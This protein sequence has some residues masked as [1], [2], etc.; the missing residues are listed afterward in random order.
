MYCD[1][2][3]EGGSCDPSEHPNS[4][5]VCAM[6]ACIPDFRIFDW[7]GSGGS[8]KEIINE[9]FPGHPRASP[10]KKHSLEDNSISEGD[11]TSAGDGQG[12]V[13]KAYVDDFYY[14]YN[15]INFHEDLTYDPIEDINIKEDEDVDQEY[16]PVHTPSMGKGNTEIL[17]TGSSHYQLTTTGPLQAS[18]SPSSPQEDQNDI[19]MESAV[20]MRKYDHD[21]QPT[22]ISNIQEG[23][24]E[25]YVTPTTTHP[26][27]VTVLVSTSS[28]VFPT[29]PVQSSGPLPVTQ[30]AVPE[31]TASLPSTHSS[32][33]YSVTKN[34]QGS[35][36]SSS[37]SELETRYNDF[38][39][40]ALDIS[41]D[42]GRGLQP[43]PDQTTHQT[44]SSRT[45]IPQTEKNGLQ[46]NSSQ[47]ILPS[48]P[49]DSSD[50]LSRS[51]PSPPSTDSAE[52][53]SLVRTT[54]HTRPDGMTSSKP[55]V[56]P[57][58]SILP[59]LTT[60]TMHIPDSNNGESTYPHLSED[61]TKGLNTTYSNQST[62]SPM[63]DDLRRSHWRVGNWTEVSLRD[64]AMKGSPLGK[65]CLETKSLQIE[66]PNNLL[67]H[68]ACVDIPQR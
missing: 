13:G 3:L 14:D 8:S 20:T 24:N 28:E 42:L 58:P 10:G 18:L 52:T 39:N 50:V 33:Q 7:T 30:H 26:D 49:K 59:F 22:P 44:P 21:E 45:F 25:E 68:I 65:K 17:S 15:F 41:S 51:P 48:V 23:E 64:G 6:P 5:Q 46:D 31:L 12:K 63:G 66:I 4:K 19:L 27:E 16:I 37:S 38:Q 34:T 55:E 36:Y 54:L 60:V 2:A 62:S 47:D 56:P 35:T 1:N 67:H 43:G 29:V 32:S 11:F 9:I 40:P 57:S 61:R 53:I